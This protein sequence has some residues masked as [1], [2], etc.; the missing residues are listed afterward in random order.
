MSWR[1]KFV[2]SLGLDP[3]HHDE[4]WKSPEN[5]IHIRE[6]KILSFGRFGSV[7]EGLEGSGRFRWVPQVGT[8]TWEAK[9]GQVGA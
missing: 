6:V 3:G 2:R 5:K 4:V 1:P 8:R 9:V 7:L